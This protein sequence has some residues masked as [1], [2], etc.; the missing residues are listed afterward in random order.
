[1]T[2]AMRIT[3]PNLLL[4]RK[5]R[6]NWKVT[7]RVRREEAQSLVELSLLMPLF[8][9]LLFGSVEVARFAWAAVLTANAARAGAAFGSLSVVNAKNLAGIQLAATN[10]SPDLVG[11][12]ATRTLSCACSDGTPTPDCTQSATVCKATVLNYVQVNTTSTVSVFGKGF[13]ATG[14]AIMAVEQ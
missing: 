12:T 10:D 1:M 11:L 6:G 3:R 14:Q 8:I 13:T 7:E 5:S 2:N 4:L 9:I